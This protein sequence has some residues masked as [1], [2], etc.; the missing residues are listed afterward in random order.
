MTK[1]SVAEAAAQ[2]NC[3]VFR[4][5]TIPTAVENRP[6]KNRVLPRERDYHLEKRGEVSRLQTL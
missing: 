1:L 6:K 5:G 4:R 3:F 2:S